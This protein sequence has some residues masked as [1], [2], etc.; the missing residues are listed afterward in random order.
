MC[1]QWGSHEG[2]DPCFVSVAPAPSPSCVRQ[3]ECLHVPHCG[4]HA[5]VCLPLFYI[6]PTYRMNMNLFIRG[7]Y[8][9]QSWHFFYLCFL[10]GFV[11]ISRN[12]TWEHMQCIFSWDF[13]AWTMTISSEIQLTSCCRPINGSLMVMRNKNTLAKILDFLQQNPNAQLHYLSL[14]CHT[15]ILQGTVM[16]LPDMKLYTILNEAVIRTKTVLKPA[17]AACCAGP[18]ESGHRHNIW[19]H[20]LW[21]DGSQHHGRSD[22]ST[23]LSQDSN[24]RDIGTSTGC[25][26]WIYVKI[27][28]LLLFQMHSTSEPKSWTWIPLWYA[29]FKYRTKRWFWLQKSLQ[30]KQNRH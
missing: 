4:T 20:G 29:L 8:G 15:D 5:R 14:K 27:L 6:L 2:L 21:A 28:L 26:L 16:K 9:L 13:T 18:W 22:T 12:H 30:S 1:R 10:M 25:V 19:F 7:L 24:T 3:A 17:L 23:P 11:Y